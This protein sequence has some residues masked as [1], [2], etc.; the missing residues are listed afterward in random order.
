[1]HIGLIGGIGPAATVAY[2]QRLVDVFGRAGV[3][4]HLT[5]QH[6]DIQILTQNA[7]RLDIDA[8]TEV[9]QAHIRSLKAAGCDV[10]GITAL[11]GHFCMPRLQDV[12]QLPILSAT[13]AINAHCV[14]HGIGR[15]GLLGSPSVLASHLFG[16]L[17]EVETVVPGEGRADV[18]RTY[19][20]IARK[21]ACTE[22]EADLLI[23]AGAEM[24]CSQK[25]HAV[26]LAGTDLGLAFNARHPSYPVIDALSLH[27]VAFL[28]TAR[29]RHASHA[30]GFEI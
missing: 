19:M 12:S 27:V 6:A 22:G 29:G 4:L 16:L 11:T 3:P 15:L 7:S 18:G 24:V 5:I 14:R 30:K 10:V 9:F 26:L 21:G 25:A 17:H 20:D 1:M 2:Y 28:E 13:T 8:Q 23:S